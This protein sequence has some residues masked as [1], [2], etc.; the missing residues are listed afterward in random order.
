MRL[1]NIRLRVCPSC[2][3]ISP[4]FLKP[5]IY[6]PD[7]VPVRDPR[8]QNFAI[9]NN[10][11]PVVPPLPWPVQPSGPVVQEIYV[12]ADNGDVILD[13]GGHPI[14]A[15]NSPIVPQR[16]V[17]VTPPLPPLP[18]DIEPDGFTEP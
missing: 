2:M 10:G 3:D 4:S 13:D 17:Y 1:V 9:P 16:P 11:S 14:I 18:Q 6:P 7:P 12:L 15:D 8:P 5:I